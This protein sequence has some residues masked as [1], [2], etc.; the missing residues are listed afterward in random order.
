MAFFRRGAR[1]FVRRPADGLQVG[2]VCAEF[3]RTRAAAKNK[4]R[5]ATGSSIADSRRDR[6]LPCITSAST[7]FARD[8]RLKRARWIIEQRAQWIEGYIAS[9]SSNLHR[10]LIDIAPAPRFARLERRDDRMPRRMEMLRRM[11]VLRIVAT[12]DMAARTAQPQMHPRVAAGETLLA[13]AAGR[14]VGPHGVQMAASIGHR[15]H[16]TRRRSVA[17]L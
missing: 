7:T 3:R 4:W 16:L 15:A 12:S 8:P 17:S 9:S 6:R 13:S 5:P 2:R 10:Q 14:L 1:R 11:P